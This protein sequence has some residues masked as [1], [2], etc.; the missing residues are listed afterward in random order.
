MELFHIPC[1]TYHSILKLH[2]V[3]M[4]LYLL[5][6]GRFGTW[7][8]HCPPQFGL[9]QVRCVLDNNKFSLWHDCVI[10]LSWGRRALSTVWV[11]VFCCDPKWL[12]CLVISLINGKNDWYY[13]MTI[14]FL[15]AN[16]YTP[17]YVNSDLQKQTN[18]STAINWWKETNNIYNDW[19]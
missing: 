6:C 2:L 4:H 19:F 8:V 18:T 14:F 1:P 7:C 13:V 11:G 5:E 16:R 12:P 3:V 10:K 9:G 17:H 15:T